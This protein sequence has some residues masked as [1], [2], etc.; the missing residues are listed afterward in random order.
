MGWIS[1][2]SGL[3]AATGCSGLEEGPGGSGRGTALGTLGVLTFSMSFAAGVDCVSPN[4]HSFG[5]LADPIFL[6]V[7]GVTIAFGSVGRLPVLSDD[8]GIADFDSIDLGWLAVDSVR[9]CCLLGTIPSSGLLRD[10]LLCPC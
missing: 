1:P 9:G 2:T 10:V 4:L 3:M 8:F 6:A 5:S 7:T